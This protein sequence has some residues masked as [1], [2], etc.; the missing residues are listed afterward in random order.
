MINKDLAIQPNYNKIHIFQL[1]HKLLNHPR[2][3]A[4]IMNNLY[5]I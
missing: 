2:I 4:I 3:L 1:F 5:F